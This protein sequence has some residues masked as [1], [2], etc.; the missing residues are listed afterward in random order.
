MSLKVSDV[1]KM[2]RDLFRSQNNQAFMSLKRSMISKLDDWIRFSEVEECAFELPFLDRPS[3]T[4]KKVVFD[5]LVKFVENRGFRVIDR[6]STFD[7]FIISWKHVD[8]VSKEDGHTLREWSATTL[9]SKQKKNLKY[10]KEAVLH[11]ILEDC[12]K[13]IKV[14]LQDSQTSCIFSI[15]HMQDDNLVDVPFIHNKLTKSLKDRGFQVSECSLK[16]SVRISWNLKGQGLSEDS[17]DNDIDVKLDE[18]DREQ[19]DTED[20]SRDSSKN[21][22]ESKQIF[23]V[24]TRFSFC[25]PDRLL[26]EYK[27]GIICQYKHLVA[28]SKLKLHLEKL[29]ESERKKFHTKFEDAYKKLIEIKTTVNQI[30]QEILSRF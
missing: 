6:S 2:E 23:S 13:T 29:E 4:S 28:L 16:N 3:S 1:Q 7:T 20:Q 11:T 22:N 17:M 19:E 26:E 14:S 21:E 18:D 24:H 8:A 25:S 15:P 10:Q 5:R 30:H 12:D 9:K 27:N